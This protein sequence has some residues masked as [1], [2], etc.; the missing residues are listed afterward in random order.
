MLIS[1]SG[2]LEESLST[3]A[4]EKYPRTAAILNYHTP[5]DLAND[6]AFHIPDFRQASLTTP[7]QS[8]SHGVARH[9]G[10]SA[11]CRPRLASPALQQ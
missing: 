3:A 11:Y 5:F 7:Q 10:E 1:M 9:P 4:G 6:I 8:F 2:W